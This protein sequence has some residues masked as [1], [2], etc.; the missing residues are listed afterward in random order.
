MTT[1]A[2]RQRRKKSDATYDLQ[3]RLDLP[4]PAISD[5]QARNAGLY[6]VGK[7]GAECGDVLEMLG[8]GGAS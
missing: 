6:V 3:A 1:Y 8:L 7:L 5:E 4:I 2:T